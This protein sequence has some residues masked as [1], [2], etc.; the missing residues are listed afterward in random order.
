MA[1]RGR[2]QPQK[3]QPRP[4]F[5]GESRWTME[6]EAACKDDDIGSPKTQRV[7]KICGI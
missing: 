6:E 1:P 2:Q 4:A 7:I 5:Q 3:S